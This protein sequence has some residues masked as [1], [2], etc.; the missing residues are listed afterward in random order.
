MFRKVRI[1]ALSVLAAAT[2]GAAITGKRLSVSG[3]RLDVTPRIVQLS[4]TL[5][6][7]PAVVLLRDQYW[8]GGLDR[9]LFIGYAGGQVIFPDSFRNW[10]PASYRTTRVQRL[11][12]WEGLNALG[13]DSAVFSLKGSYDLAPDVSDQETIWLLVW[14]NGLLHKV[15]V[16]GG[17]RNDS[18]FVPGIPLP[19][20]HAYRRLRAFRSADAVA[21]RPE[22]VEVA[23]WRYEYA[24]Y[25]PSLQWPDSWPNLKSPGV[26][27]HDD[28]AVGELYTFMMPG[29]QMAALDSF[30]AQR[31]G[32]QAVQISERKW[33]VGYR[34]TYPG[35]HLWRDAV[36]NLV[37]ESLLTDLRLHGPGNRPLSRRGSRC[38]AWLQRSAIS[39]T[40]HVIEDSTD[41]A[42]PWGSVTPQGSDCSWP[43][44][45]NGVFEIEV[46]AA[47]SY[48]IVVGHWAAT[49][50]G[51]DTFDI[52]VGSDGATDPNVLRLRTR[53]CDNKGSGGVRM[54]GVI[55]SEAIG[56]LER[57]NVMVHGSECRTWTDS[58]GRWTLYGVPRDNRGLSVFYGGYYSQLLTVPIAPTE[59]ASRLLDIILTPCRPETRVR[60]D[61]P[62]V[63]TCDKPPD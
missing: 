14:R 47:G 36:R 23:I 59:G 30:L 56:P 48:R 58:L 54:S 13:V 45:A 34:Y 15:A 26:T 16:R 1:A 60:G 62:P 7:R 24:P 43:L 12:T 61:R 46:P 20:Q 44:L 28:P 41:A 17:Q 27:R 3:T 21:W 10:N 8:T 63:G 5:D 42:P 52:R 39:A 55:R 37:A 9:P 51:N 18:A 33:A 4:D 2:Y 22:S 6:N 57:V 38:D 25:S 53:P 19:F 11:D 49:D 35:D 40:G 50:F 29:S 32:R 31:Q